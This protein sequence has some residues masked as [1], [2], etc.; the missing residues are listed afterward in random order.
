MAFYQKLLGTA[1]TELPAL[2][3]PTVRRGPRLSDAS[4]TALCLP[5]SFLEI[6]QALF[7]IDDVKAPGLDGLRDVPDFNFHPKFEK[8]K[9]T[10]LMFA[11]D[12]L[13]F[14]RGDLVSIQLLF[15]AFQKFSSC[16]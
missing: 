11:S 15:Q 14:A 12:L 6:D 13:L 3:L 8:L 16:S 9:I 4:C 1:A 10:H 5:I 2:H 7:A